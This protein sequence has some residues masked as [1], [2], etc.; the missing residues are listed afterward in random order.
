MMGKVGVP[1]I[2]I[3]VPNPIFVFKLDA[4]LLNLPLVEGQVCARPDV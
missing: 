3:F 4:V 1:V 2:L